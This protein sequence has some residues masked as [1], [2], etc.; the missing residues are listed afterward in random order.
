[1]DGSQSDEWS[2]RKGAKDEA[3]GLSAERQ[4]LTPSLLWYLGSLGVG[5]QCVMCCR[6]KPF[7]LITSPVRALVWS[8]LLTAFLRLPSLPSFPFG[9]ASSGRGHHPPCR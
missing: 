7:L 5:A 1:M 2:A 9:S 6:C 3:A 4:R 8:T